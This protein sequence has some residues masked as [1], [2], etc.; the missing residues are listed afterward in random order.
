[1]MKAEE[2]LKRYAVGERNFQRVNLRGQSFKGQNLSGADF[3]RADICSTNFTGATLR[4]VNFTGAKCGLR[5]RWAILLRIVS[6]LLVFVSAFFSIF[7]LYVV[8]FIFF[9]IPNNLFTSFSRTFFVGLLVL[10]TSFILVAIFKGIVLGT[11]L[12]AF[13]FVFVTLA[14]V[15]KLKVVSALT[16]VISLV[17]VGAGAFTFLIVG[18]LIFEFAKIAIEKEAKV[19]IVF[20]I[21]MITIMFTTV[22]IVPLSETKEIVEVFSL[23]KILFPLTLLF[24]YIRNKKGVKNL[25]L[26]NFA[27]AFATIGGTSFKNA[28]LTDANFTSA[29]LKSTDFRN[30]TLTRVCWYGAKMLDRVRLGD[31][32]LKN[33]QLRQWL[34]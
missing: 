12:W 2:V 27:I 24:I 4:G 9:S 25:W 16:A 26:F 18:I 20:A 10:I 8:Q 29:K 22:S 23:V 11:I 28:D 3:S 15:I 14:I 31:T 21:C 19:L 17:L 34:N 5:R 6:W 1:M 33:T 30:A 7:S 13:L 32:Y